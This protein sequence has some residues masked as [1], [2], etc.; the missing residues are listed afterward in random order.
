MM[1]RTANENA[2]CLRSLA[3]LF[4]SLSIFG[5]SDLLQILRK[6]AAFS[7]AVLFIIMFN[8]SVFLGPLV[9]L[10][11]ICCS[12]FNMVWPWFSCG[13]VCVCPQF[14]YRGNDTI[15]WIFPI[16]PCNAFCMWHWPT[17]KD[18][19]LSIIWGHHH[20][21]I[22]GLW[23]SV[24][25]LNTSQLATPCWRDPT[26]SKQLSTDAIWLS[27]WTLSCRSPVKLSTSISLASL[28]TCVFEAWEAY[29]VVKENGADYKNTAANQL[30][31]VPSNRMV[32]M[33][34]PYF[35]ESK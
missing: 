2:A 22:V 13:T 8:C 12:F 1:Q 33:D 15:F 18:L 23:I 14:P 21:H 10:D 28:F 6:Q 26:R 32:L 34:P 3:S 17:G 20:L 30:K 31:G 4:T 9:F 25:Q 35:L 27:V 11:P 5:W 7:F 24:D 16:V 29:H 19:D